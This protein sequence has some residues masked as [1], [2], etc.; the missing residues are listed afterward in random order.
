MCPQNEWE[1]SRGS[2]F[3]RHII[4]VGSW[5]HSFLVVLTFCGRTPKG[6]C[7]IV[8]YSMCISLCD[9]SISVCTYAHTHTRLQP[10]QFNGTSS[11]LPLLSSLWMAYKMASTPPH[12]LFLHFP[13]VLPPFLWTG[14]CPLQLKHLP[15]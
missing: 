1:E 15:E 7:T 11:P 5:Q 9:Y 14:T 8:L 12:P 13:S 3:L 2:S 10:L 4:V 6:V